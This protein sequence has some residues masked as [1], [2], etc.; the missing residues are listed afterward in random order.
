MSPKDDSDREYLANPDRWTT[1]PAAPVKHLTRRDPMPIVGLV[2][3]E[4]RSEGWRVY[5]ANLW[6]SKSLVAHKLHAKYATLDDLLK[7]WR[8]D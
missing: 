3:D 8:V 4:P 2:L 1:W 5:D 7:E 6:D